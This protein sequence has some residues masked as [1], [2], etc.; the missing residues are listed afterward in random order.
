MVILVIVLFVGFLGRAVASGLRDIYQSLAAPGEGRE[1]LSGYLLY[2]FERAI[3]FLGRYL[4]ISVSDLRDAALNQTEK[5]VAVLLNITAG[6]LGSLTSSV[7]NAFFAFFVL[8][9]FFRDGRG[10]L[11]RAAVVLPLKR[12][13]ARR[14][15]I[16]VRDTLHAIVL[17][18]SPWRHCKALLQVLLSGCSAS[19]RLS[20]G[21]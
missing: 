4:P 17:R 1:R 19:A 2:L 8:F 6:A 3:E 10:M 11:R 16:R 20:F 13:H 9:F 15:L 12:E 5:W 18:R 21:P 14:L 7:A